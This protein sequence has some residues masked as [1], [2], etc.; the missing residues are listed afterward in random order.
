MAVLWGEVEEKVDKDIS[1]LRASVEVCV[2]VC[3]CV[4]GGVSHIKHLTTA[5]TSECEAHR[6]HHA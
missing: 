5:K 2:C 6:V 1:Q 3:V 4:D